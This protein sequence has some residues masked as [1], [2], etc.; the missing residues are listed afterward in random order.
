MHACAYKI[1]GFKA[2]QELMV[3]S[4]KKHW[5]GRMMFLSGRSSVPGN[6]KAVVEINGIIT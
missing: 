2:N 1:Q 4:V 5:R 6:Y 3:R